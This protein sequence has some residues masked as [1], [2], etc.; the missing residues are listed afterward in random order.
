[1]IIKLRNIHAK[2]KLLIQNICVLLA[3]GNET[4]WNGM[5]FGVRGRVS[6]K[7]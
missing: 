7:G 5:G 2:L 1:M 4:M 6:Y 3:N